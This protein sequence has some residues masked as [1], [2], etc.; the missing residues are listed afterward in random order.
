MAKTVFAVLSI[1]KPEILGPKI[2]QLYPNDSLKISHNEWLIAAES[3]SQI[4]SKELGVL[5]EGAG[6]ALIVALSGYFGRMPTTVWEWIKLKWG[7]E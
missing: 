4:L 1:S 3:T 7:S 6:T 5:E 2:Q